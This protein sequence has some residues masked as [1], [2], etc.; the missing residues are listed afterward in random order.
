MSAMKFLET[1]FVKTTVLIFIGVI[2]LG[3]GCAAP[4][5]KELGENH[6]ANP[7]AAASAA[8]RFKPVLM[9]AQTGTNAPAKES[10]DHDDHKHKADHD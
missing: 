7:K 3:A 1:T 9:T 10:H 6:P 2:G 8:P 4:T 5:A